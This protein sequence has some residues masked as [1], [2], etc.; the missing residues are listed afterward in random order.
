[1]EIRFE[2]LRRIVERTPGLGPVA[3]RMYA[4]ISPSARPYGFRSSSQYWED[5]YSSGGNSG[6][7]SYGRQAEFKAKVLNR[8]VND[9]QVRTV[10]EF[11]C[12][13]GAQLEL[14]DYPNY[15][16][17][18]VSTRAVELC[19]TKFGNDGSKRFLVASDAEVDG[20]WAEM[21]L[22][23]DVIYH[24]VEDEVYA[25]YM[26]RL[27][28]AATRFIAIYS[29]DSDEVSPARHVRH[30]LFTEWMSN[31]AQ[32]WELFERVNNPYQQDPDEL[33]DTWWADFY[34]Y[35]KKI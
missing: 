7:G 3:K 23:L 35:R 6:M 31:N 30:R 33:G 20:L 34:F 26:T 32:S 4:S 1:V 16:G 15:V 27:A 28:S 24:L 8:F 14:T 11:G 18:D 19:R 2:R 9:H 29:D 21:T 10:L 22:S 5:R 13:D 17:V 12:G 25:Q